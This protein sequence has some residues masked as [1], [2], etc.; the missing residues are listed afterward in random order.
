M[1][2]IGL[3]TAAGQPCLIRFD[4]VNPRAVEW[5]RDRSSWLV[6][7]IGAETR[8]ALRDIVRRAFEQGIPPRQAASLIRDVVGLRSDQVEAVMNLRQRIEEAATAA[9][10]SG[11]SRTVKFGRNS[12]KV[13]P[14][15]LG[16]DRTSRVLGRYAEKL[17]RDRALLIAR[18]ETIASSV[19][20]QQELWHQSVQAGLLRG[21]EV[22][23]WIVTKD[24]RLCSICAPMDRVEV[25]LDGEFETSE[26][27]VPGPP[28]HPACRCSLVLGPPAE[29]GRSRRA[30]AI[31]AVAEAYGRLSACP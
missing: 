12:I 5:A 27:R 9:A 16:A 29:R 18:T 15:G 1:R 26:G 3:V 19:R 4:R 11:A 10:E 30:S 14:G 24:E 20:G 13:P 31:E 22:Q 6:T 2:R 23:R 7:E 21:N 8:D 17:R 25:P 28:A